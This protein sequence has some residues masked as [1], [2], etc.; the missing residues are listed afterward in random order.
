MVR[1]L[2][3]QRRTGTPGHTL[4]TLS[5]VIPVIDN[6]RPHVAVALGGN[7]FNWLNNNGRGY[8]TPER[9]SSFWFRQYID[10]S[11]RFREIAKQN[12]ADIVISNHTIY[13]GSRTKLPAVLA[14]KAGQPNPYVIGEDAVQRYLTIFNE[15]AQAGLAR[16]N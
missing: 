2:C 11:R 9:P 4:G 10:S 8:I 1:A 15:C 7:L 3:C 12:G 5:T 13:D 6:G 16:I 14:R